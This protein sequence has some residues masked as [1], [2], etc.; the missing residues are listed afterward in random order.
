MHKTQQWYLLRLKT[1][2][3]QETG[4]RRQDMWWLWATLF[5]FLF[6]TAMESVL[7]DHILA[8]DSPLLSAI[9]LNPAASNPFTVY[10][11]SGHCWPQSKPLTSVHVSIKLDQ[12]HHANVL[13]QVEHPWPRRWLHWYLGHASTPPSSRGRTPLS[14]TRFTT[15]PFVAG[16]HM[17]EHVLTSISKPFH[18]INS[19]HHAIYTKAQSSLHP[20]QHHPG[21]SSNIP[22]VR[23]T[24]GLVIFKVNFVSYL[25][26]QLC[27]SI[28]IK[29]Q[30]PFFCHISR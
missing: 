11:S 22:D 19:M 1:P 6:L 9:A 23:K 2:H 30:V 20:V 24:D 15:S 26:S 21:A 5:S 8:W 27:I 12:N 14:P 29:C 28:K 16:D 13:A 4:G 25:V 7:A 17:A 18:D 3:A 10:I